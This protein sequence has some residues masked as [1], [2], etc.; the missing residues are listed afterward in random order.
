M[1]C[2]IDKKKAQPSPAKPSRF[3]ARQGKAQMEA[4]GTAAATNPAAQKQKN[5][6]TNGH[7][8]SSVPTVCVCVFIQTPTQ[9]NNCALT[10]CEI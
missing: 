6:C 3:K 1:H 7:L 8:Y 5:E 9:G 10:R 2:V 4:I